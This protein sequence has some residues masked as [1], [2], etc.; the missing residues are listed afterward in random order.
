MNEKGTLRRIYVLA[1]LKWCIIIR[2]M[3]VYRERNAYLAMRDWS[4][5][6]ILLS[7]C[8][9][10]FGGKIQTIIDFSIF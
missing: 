7:F 4:F 1:V 6:S 5:S 9:G 2:E 10:I 8:I 3:L